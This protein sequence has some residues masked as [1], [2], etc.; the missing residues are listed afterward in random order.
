MR[1]CAMIALMMLAGCSSA[2]TYGPFDMNNIPDKFVFSK[3]VNVYTTEAKRPPCQN[4][5]AFGRAGD[6]AVRCYKWS[7]VPV[8]E[9]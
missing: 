8:E 5:G 6:P 3:P 2:K 9:R 1:V 7:S 4:P